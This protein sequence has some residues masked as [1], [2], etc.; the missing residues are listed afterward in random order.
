M[1]ILFNP[2]YPNKE[3]YSITHIINLMGYA[4]TVN[5]NESCDIGFLWDDKTLVN[6]PDVLLKLA[7][8]TPVININCTDIS[9]TTVDHI[10]TQIFGYSNIIEPLTH[11]GKCVE[12]PNE[13]GVKGGHVID[14][15]ISKIKIG[16]IYQNLIDSTMD[17]Y[18][19]EY[20]V[21]VILNEIAMVCLVKQRPA[22]SSLDF[23]EQLPP[24]PLA[25]EQAFDAHEAHQ[26]LSFCLKINLDFGELDIVRCRQTQRLFILD[27]NKTPA[28]YG[29]LN[30]FHWQAED[31][32]QVLNNLANTFDRKIKQLIKKDLL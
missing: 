12:K 9:K 28:G 11:T 19:H 30:Y 24:I 5:P 21:A 6:C 1:K 7:K 2:D 18:Q 22:K 4:V 31:K 29:M 8:H 14:C 3:F 27:A 25:I 23:R 20:R 16:C 10:S 15:P 17:G 13:N 32:A 26:I